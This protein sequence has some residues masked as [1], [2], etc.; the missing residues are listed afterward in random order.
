MNCKFSNLREKIE[1]FHR[2]AIGEGFLIHLSEDLL[3]IADAILAQFPV[4]NYHSQFDLHKNKCILTESK[5]ENISNN[6]RIWITNQLIK[7][8]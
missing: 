5:T 1:I 2:N 7:I 3:A 6:F 4:R 8:F